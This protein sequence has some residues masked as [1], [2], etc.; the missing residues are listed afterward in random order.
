MYD[1]TNSRLR[2]PQLKGNAIYRRLH[3]N[4]K[5]ELMKK[6]FVP[7]I[8]EAQAHG[9]Y[10]GLLFKQEWRNK[11][12]IILQRDGNSCFICKSTNSLQVH[13]RQYHFVV[14]ENKL[15]DPW[16]Y[17]NYLLISLCSDCHKKGHS[18]YKVPIVHV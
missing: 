12:Q 17:P 15:K 4:N 2:F 1:L 5:G 10:G 3:K 18:K 7:I 14:R 11:R 9:S 16:D 6:Q 8:D 13:H